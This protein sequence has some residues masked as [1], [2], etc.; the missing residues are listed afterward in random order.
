MLD[1]IGNYLILFAIVL[2]FN[3][4]FKT[5]AIAGPYKESK[6][7]YQATKYLWVSS[8]LFLVLSF[9]ILIIAFVKTDLSLKVVYENSSSVKPLMYKIAAVWGHHEGSM[10]L[11]CIDIGIAGII[12]MIFASNRAFKNRVLE[13]LSA[14]LLLFLTYIY[15]VSNPFAINFLPAVQGV[16]L[17]PILQDIGLIIHPP[18]LYFGYVGFVLTYALCVVEGF[19]KKGFP[20]FASETRIWT[21]LSWIL[22]TFGIMMGSKWS[23]REMGWGGY[24]FWDPVENASLMPW[25]AGL[26][27]LHGLIVYEKKKLMRS[28]CIFLGITTFILSVLGTFIV[29]SGIINSVHTFAKD[30][31]RGV[32]ILVILLI[33]TILG[34]SS[35]IYSYITSQN[36]PINRFNLFSKEAAILVQLLIAIV[37]LLV[38]ITGTLY[39]TILEF[40]FDIK[41]SVGAPYYQGIIAPLVYIAIFF[42]F[43]ATNINWGRNN[44]KNFFMKT[45][46]EM[47]LGIIVFTLI[48]YLY[49]VLSL[50]FVST[51]IAVYSFSIV[52]KYVR[53][54]NITL[55]INEIIHLAFCLMVLAIIGNS[56]FSSHKTLELTSHE[57]KKFLNYDIGLE[58]VRYYKKDN[59]LVEE[60]VI[61]INDRKKRYYAFPQRRF[62]FVEQNMSSEIYKISLGL[63]DL[64]IALNGTGNTDKMEY[65]SIEVSK[66]S[67]INLLWFSSFMLLAACGARLVLH[68][69][70]YLSSRYY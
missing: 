40:F 24:W 37:A 70:Y 47:L 38:V 35:S 42:S 6:V 22:L 67:M 44:I 36:K 3:N 68:L 59:Y 17:N 53:N 31:S 63:S 33:L 8:V 9:V 23:Y 32:F 46:I 45:Y 50:A 10:L 60:A 11:W 25:I 52:R 55:A 34:V 20:S 21:F 7:Y 18:S 19:S 12:H 49:K 56:L 51:I 15:F 62:Y 48:L 58:E 13:L 4:A 57:I 66:K 26:A 41:I 27:L 30:T 64:Y 43:F 61:A 14:I 29:R 39:P 69:V 1:L 28:F 5:L 54:K 2:V 65:I 16:G